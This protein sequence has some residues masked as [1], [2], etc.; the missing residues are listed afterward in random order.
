MSTTTKRTARKRAAVTYA[1]SDSESEDE[2]T[3]PKKTK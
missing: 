2:K 3:P 1:I